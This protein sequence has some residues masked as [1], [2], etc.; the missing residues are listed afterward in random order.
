MLKIKNTVYPKGKIKTFAEWRNYIKLELMYTR[1]KN[2][3]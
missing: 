3:K 1:I 2:K